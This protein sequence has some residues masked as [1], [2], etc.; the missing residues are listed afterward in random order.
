MYI[1]LSL[2]LPLPLQGYEKYGDLKT[3]FL[4]FHVRL[5]QPNPIR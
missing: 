1:Q 5:S 4:S 2:A 3:M